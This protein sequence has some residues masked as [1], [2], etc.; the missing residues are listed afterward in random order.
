MITP[1]PIFSFEAEMEPPLLPPMTSFMSSVQTDIPEEPKQ[2]LFAEPAFSYL[3]NMDIPQ[4]PGLDASSVTQTTN[5]SD[6]ISS[7][8]TSS[9]KPKKKIRDRSGRTDV[10]TKKVLRA[11]RS[12]YFGLLRSLSTGKR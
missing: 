3:P 4:K 1:T 11:C 5:S 6:D 7:T 12:Y 9:E 8:T 2:L 10:T